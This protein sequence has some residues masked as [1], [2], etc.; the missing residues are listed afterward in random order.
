MLP[1]NLSFSTAWSPVPLYARGRVIFTDVPLKEANCLSS[2]RPVYTLDEIILPP[3]SV[4]KSAYTSQLSMSKNF[5]CL[6]YWLTRD[7]QI[8]PAVYA[9]YRAA[10]NGTMSSQYLKHSDI[11]GAGKPQQSKRSRLQEARAAGESDDIMSSRSSSLF[12]FCFSS[13]MLIVLSSSVGKSKPSS[14]SMREFTSAREGPM[15]P[16]LSSSRAR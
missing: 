4:P 8:R 10:S 5:D 6:S 15:L 7:M 12:F 16:L 11:T 1:G 2:C 9:C 13:L 14:S 3:T